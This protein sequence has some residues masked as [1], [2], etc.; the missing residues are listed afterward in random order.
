MVLMD[1]PKT[2]SIH[3]E[4]AACLEAPDAVQTPGAYRVEDVLKVSS[5]ETTQLV[6]LRVFGGRELGPYVRKLIARGSGVG[7]AYRSLYRA[8]SSGKRFRQLPRIV[9]VADTGRATEVVME[10][11]KGATLRE[12]VDAARDADRATLAR[13]LMPAVCDAVLELHEGFEAPIVHRD[14]TPRNIICPEADPATPVLID[15]GIAR[16]WRE[17]AE[18][19]TTHFGTR[20]YA[21]PEQFGFGQTDVR[22]DVYALGM[23]A[24]FC[25][26]GRDPGPEDREH[27]FRCSPVGPAWREV[28]A[29]AG[30]LDPAGRYQ[31]VRELKAA[32]QAASETE[33]SIRAAAEAEAAPW[34]TGE[35]EATRSGREAAAGGAPAAGSAD[36]KK[37]VPAA[38]PA[39]RRGAQGGSCVSGAGVAEKPPRLFTLR[40]V[41]VLSIWVFLTL[42]TFYLPFSPDTDL[43]SRPVFNLVGYF[44]WLP[45]LYALVTYALM[46]RRWLFARVPV[47]RGREPGLVAVRMVLAYALITAGWFVL[48]VL[49]W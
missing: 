15:L 8:Q 31:G 46:D 10:H 42:M 7:G 37:D 6:Y 5:V 19:D 47:L 41:I 22:S 39:S 25:L 38:R 44:L 45:G 3:D 27:G 28:I 32:F 49:G 30:A 48:A 16:E 13:L 4:L 26:T 36:G 35:V 9:S 18:A 17:G 43:G 40:N 1:A 14:L 11:V 21:P 20:S 23:L 33:V 24:F 29:K 34:E 2:D 12:V